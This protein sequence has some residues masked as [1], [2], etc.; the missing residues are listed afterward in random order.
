MGHPE[1]NTTRPSGVFLS[2]L[3]VT[4]TIVGAPLTAGAQ[5]F[6][7][8]EVKVGG[9]FDVQAVVPDNTLS[10]NDFVLG[11]LG[12]TV[13]SEFTRKIKA[14]LEVAY[15]RD[16]R[17]VVD[18]AFIDWTFFHRQRRFV[19][20]QTAGLLH[21]GLKIG[22][23]DIPFGI[24]WKDYSSFERPLITM[25]LVVAN[26][27]RGWNDVGALFFG[28][29]TWSNWA[30]WTVNGFEQSPGLRLEERGHTPPMPP[31]LGA[32]S[33]R[34]PAAED[35]E[36]PVTE[37]IGIRA[38]IVISEVFE[39]GTSFGAGY[40]EENVQDEKLIGFDLTAQYEG[41]EFKTEFIR[42]ERFRTTEG[43]QTVF[44]YYLQA[45][46]GTDHFFGVF[47]QDTYE[48]DN[49]EVYPLGITATDEATFCT[50]IGA[51]FKAD[52]KVEIRGEYRLCE[53][54]HN[55]MAVVQAVVGF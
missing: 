24:D 30:V 44:G 53:G 13:T 9:H 28:S 46:Y 1:R 48:P 16:D 25:P 7:N 6:D 14:G 4:A 10:D 41:F 35:W 40:T 22:R 18:E 11:Q 21:L 43:E 42:Q 17:I 27:H 45:L 23:F 19:R 49:S 33:G 50:S 38:A 15:D 36:C 54:S 47:R 5:I 31:P 34:A 29:T 32:L 20:P 8:G 52:P 37:A 39:F 2:I 12:V 3:L 55:D 51:G 26:T